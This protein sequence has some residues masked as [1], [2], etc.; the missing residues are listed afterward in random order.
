M[1]TFTDLWALC[2]PSWAYAVHAWYISKA[3]QKYVGLDWG[4]EILA[5]DVQVVG[6]RGPAQTWLLTHRKMK[7]FQNWEP[8]IELSFTDPK[9]HHRDGGVA[10]RRVP[11]TS[12]AFNPMQ[13]LNPLWYVLGRLAHV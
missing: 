3:Q 12:L 7:L 9:A 13:R 1:M 2:T 11:T 4:S 8:I 6:D 5:L 10:S